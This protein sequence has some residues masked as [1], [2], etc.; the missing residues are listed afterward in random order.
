MKKIF[1][2]LDAQPNFAQLEEKV[3][4]FWQKEDIF[5]KSLI[6]NDGKEKFVIYDGPPT[7]NAKPPLHTMVPMSFKDLVGRYKTMQ[8]YFVP[9]Q[10]GWDTHGLPV[11]VQVEKAMGLTSKKD[12]LNLVPGDEKASIQQFNQACRQSVWEFKQE[13]DKFVPRVGYFTD[14]LHPYITYEND[15]IEKVWSVFKRIWDKEMVYKGY[16]VLPYCPRCGTALSAAEVAQEYHNL[17]DTSVY[18]T[19]PLKDNP[20]RFFLAWTTTPWTLP[21]NVA[22]AVH[23]EIQYVVVK[24][25]GGEYILAKDRLEVLRGDYIILEEM[26]G[27]KLLGRQYLPIFSGSIDANSQTFQ[28]FGADFVNTEEGTGVVHTAVMYGVDDFS[29]GE[30]VGLPMQHTVDLEG[31]F[32]QK[33][34]EFA[35][36]NVREAL[37][38]ILTS[39]A[40]KGRLYGK[41]IIT[42]SYPLCWRCKTPLIYY[43]KDSWF[44]AMSKQREGLIASNN[45]V[46]WFPDYIKEG[47]FGD[48]I[49][50]ARDWAISRERFWGTP[51][52]VW[53]SK[54]GK[55]L[56]IGSLKELKSLAKE[57]KQITSDFDLHRPFIDEI[58]LLKDGEEYF[59]E[60]LVLDVWFDS[61]SM[62]FASHREEKGEFPANYISEAIDQTRGWF[63]TLQAISSLVKGVSA[64]QNVTCIGHLVDE[65]GK[66][67]SKSLGNVFNPW[68]TFPVYG[69]DTIRW[70]I[71]TVN[72][73]GEA[74]ALS[75][76]ELQTTHRKSVLLLW[77]VVNYYLTYANLHHINIPTLA[78]RQALYSKEA[79]PELEV[80]DRWIL[81]KQI[82]VAQEVTRTLNEYDFMRAGRLLEKY[83]ND[84]ST[85]YLRRSRRRE[86][87]NFFN[88]MYDVL[89]NLITMNAPFI[90][91]VTETIYQALRQ[92]D[93]PQ[94]I[95]LLDWVKLNFEPD[96]EV[97]QKMELVRQAVEIGLSLR[98]QT[99]IKVRQPLRVAFVEI[100]NTHLE[101]SYLDILADELNVLEV[102][103]GLEIGLPTQSSEILTVSLDV[104]LDDQLIL[105]GLGR[106]FLRQ[107]QQQRKQ[108]GLKPGELV[109]LIIDPSAQE[110]VE[111]ILQ[112]NPEIA[113]QAFL[114]QIIWQATEQYEFLLGEQNV[115]IEL[116]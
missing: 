69:V 64:F 46:N 73:P 55:M 109:K 112:T 50:E 1:T 54:S 114:S 111:E 107:I 89:I 51:I 83:L 84:L 31:N 10:A 60:P 66:K 88:V 116:A 59:R 95:H 41:Q 97:M 72:S 99:K 43:A 23:E 52:P 2:K 62:P 36:Q 63:Y 92:T 58:V 103:T 47:R 85:W 81:S 115:F 27:K 39:L 78:E 33:V 96:L 38:N 11:E 29:L 34:K 79:F 6:K 49:R 18:V 57:P 53:V 70:W 74:K 4:G 71:Y 56:C 87:A 20:N 37:P 98:V 93:D 90:P 35:G 94:S 21:G 25:E 5:N 67:M 7:A 108:K 65:N 32:N 16:K 9:R 86:D 3:L 110:L 17:K 106:D 105:R 19:F 42:H 76:K 44:I 15:Y 13:W 24:Q 26:P 102:R 30:K 82:Q 80:L 68:E 104:Q 75:P 40:E 22:L 14:Y 91:F 61:G 12:I 8:G 100:K 45:T 48:F 28:V 77:N 101:Q 113:E